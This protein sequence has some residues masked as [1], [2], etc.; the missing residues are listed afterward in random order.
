M[1]LIGTHYWRLKFFLLFSSIC[2][3]FLFGFTAQALDRHLTKAEVEKLKKN[4]LKEPNNLVS[5]RFLMDHYAKEK[6]WPEYILVAQPVQK[7]LPAAEQLFLVKTYLELEDGKG[8]LAVIGFYQSQHGITSETKILE[9]EAL[10]LLAEEDPV[11]T[12]RRQKAIEA[13][14]I[15]REAVRLNPENKTAYLRWIEVLQL[16]WTNYAEDA[17]QVYSLLETATKN[18]SGYLNEKCALYVDAALWDHALET[19]KRSLEQANTHIESYINLAKA[20]NIKLSLQ[21]SKKTLKA[22]VKRFP[23]STD[24]HKALAFDYFSEN[25]FI[26]AAEHYKK[27]TLLNP[28]DSESFLY[29]AQSEFQQKKYLEALESYKKNCHLSRTLASEFKHSTGELRSHYPLHNKY[30]KVMSSCQ[31]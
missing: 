28:T 21:E 1:F 20:Q 13:I 25:N 31:K 12:S 14:A 17:L 19:C 15:L 5:R 3:F 2:L 11:E 22:L 29:L 23:N 27:A 30:K 26:S 9:A 8:A 24:A 10:T 4:I 16:F 18:T 6:K 7:D